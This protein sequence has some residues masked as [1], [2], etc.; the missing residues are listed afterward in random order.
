MSLVENNLIQLVPSVNHL[1]AV[2]CVFP[3]FVAAGTADRIVTAASTTV[4]DLQ[5]RILS[6]TS[7]AGPMTVHSI[8]G[9]AMKSRKGEARLDQWLKNIRNLHESKPPPS[10][11]FGRRMPDVEE[12]MQEWPK[13]IEVI[14]GQLQP[15]SAELNISLADYA[16]LICVLL[17]I[18]VPATTDGGGGP[19]SNAN[20]ATSGPTRKVGRGLIESLY[21]LFTL[22]AE[23][24]NSQHFVK[25]VGE[26][27]W[28]TNA[29][30]AGGDAEGPGWGR[31]EGGGMGGSQESG[32]QGS[33]ISEY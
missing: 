2:T 9:E 14:W 28:P 7:T 3:F 5:L 4:L 22:Y 21:M 32:I 17:D 13:E 24:R 31:G 16:R 26:G 19:S 1:C 6:K 11:H 33:V 23:F 12:L 30:V 10:V 8:D 15:P 27:W 29:L 20:P 18:P 25:S